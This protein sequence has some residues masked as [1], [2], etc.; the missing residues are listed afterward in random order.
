MTLKLN[1]DKESLTKLFKENPEFELELSSA[2]TNYIVQ[3]FYEKN[4]S[5]IIAAADP[6]LFAKATKAAQEDAE[7][8]GHVDNALKAK[9][10]VRH[11]SYY[12]KFK[13]APALQKAVDDVVEQ[14]KERALAD[15]AVIIEKALATKIKEILDNKLKNLD[16]DAIMD[17]KIEFLTNAKINEMVNERFEQRMADFKAMFK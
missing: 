10:T 2:V 4:V 17:R 5:R 13:P 16:I 8:M 11:P 1:I 9:L 7:F 6:L 14:K 12:D 15:A 3:K